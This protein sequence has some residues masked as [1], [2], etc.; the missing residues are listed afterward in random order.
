MFKGQIFSLLCLFVGL[1]QKRFYDIALCVRSHQFRN[2]R[3]VIEA[4][5]TRLTNVI[6]ALRRN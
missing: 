6:S 3:Q 4:K 5:R 1:L 2:K